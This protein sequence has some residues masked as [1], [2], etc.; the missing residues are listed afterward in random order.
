MKCNIILIY[1]E[2]KSIYSLL[3]DFKLEFYVLKIVLKILF[4][5]VD[6]FSL[7]VPENNY[8]SH[9]MF[10]HFIKRWSKKK[11]ILLKTSLII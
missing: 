1:N 7:Y 3:I 8:G 6:D 11:K 4:D 9:I 10:F 5:P 2:Y